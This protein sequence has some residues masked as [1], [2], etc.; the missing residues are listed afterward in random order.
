[1]AVLLPN[2]SLTL[3]VRDHPFP[4]RDAHGVPVA[5][6]AI[7]ETRG[8]LPGATLERAVNDWVLRLAPEMWPVK[9]GDEVSDG[10]RTWVVSAASLHRVPG[11]P[12]ADY[13]SV[14]GAL[15]PPDVP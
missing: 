8:P 4:T 5:T 9:A 2:A 1:M 6:V 7:E 11:H 15:N 12:D 14:V 3:L 13:V 10:E